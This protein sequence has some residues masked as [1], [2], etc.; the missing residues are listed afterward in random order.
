MRLMSTALL[1]LF[2]LTACG[3]NSTAPAEPETAPAPPAFERTDYADLDTWL[4]HPGK[5]VNDACKVDL[6]ATAIAEDGTT[7]LEPFTPAAEPAFDCFYVYPTVSL[8]MAPNSDLIPGAEER[9]VAANQFARY[10]QQCRLFA[11]M[12][13]QRTILDLQTYV[14]TGQSSADLEMRWADVMDS[15]NQYLTTENQGRG[16]LLVGHSQGADMVLQLLEKEIVGKP[17]Q[18]QIIGVHSIGFTAHVDASGAFKGMPVCLAAGQAGCLVNYES[19]RATAEPPASS[20][21]AIASDT[22][23]RAICTNPA[24]LSGTGETLD[25]YMP[26]KSFGTNTPTDY[27]AAVE[28]PFVKLPGLL[29]GECLSNAT[30]DWLAVTVQAGEGPRADTIPGD[31]VIG[32]NVLAEWG[33]HL[34]DMNI[35]MGNLVEIAR[36]QAEGWQAAQ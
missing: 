36:L 24:A 23:A 15:W 3:Q 27:G 11:P 14:T 6:T 17:V 7:T 34:V 20:R 30:H 28:T 18:A 21:F 22:G 10:G 32:G 33:L 9:S 12:Y 13:R 31:V 29:S 1:G 16:I 8:D 4:C 35:A 2:L 26:A 25:A 19:F 5:S